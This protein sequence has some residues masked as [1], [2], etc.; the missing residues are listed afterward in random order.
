MFNKFQDAYITAQKKYLDF[1][2]KRFALDMFNEVVPDRIE[3]NYE[4]FLIKPFWKFEIL[5]P[6]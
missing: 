4:I 5:K 1:T 3:K 2:A 6:W